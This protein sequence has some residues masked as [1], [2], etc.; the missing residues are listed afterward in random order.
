[1][2]PFQADFTAN[3]DQANDCINEFI[4]RTFNPL[5]VVNFRFISVFLQA[6]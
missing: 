1:M 5:V 2:I 3:P 4:T 6:L